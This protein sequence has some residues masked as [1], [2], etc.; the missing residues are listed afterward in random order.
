MINLNA[1][2]RKIVAILCLITVDSFLAI[3]GFMASAEETKC[4]YCGTVYGTNDGTDIVWELN[5]EGLLTLSG[6]GQMYAGS[7]GEYSKW[8]RYRNEIEEV[9]VG[10]NITSIGGYAFY[11]CENLKSIVLPESLE[12]I[13]ANAFSGCSSLKNIELPQG[14]ELLGERAFNGCSSLTD[15]VFPESIKTINRYC[16]CECTSLAEVVVPPNVTKLEYEVFGGCT[17]LSSVTLSEGLETLSNKVFRDCPI[18]KIYLPDSVQSISFF[19]FDGCEK[20][21]EVSIGKN[22]ETIGSYAFFENKSLKKVEYR[23]DIDSWIRINFISNP[24]EYAGDLYIDGKVVTKVDF[25]EGF[26]EIPKRVFQGCKSI[27]SI[28]IPGS[29]EKIGEYA[30]SGCIGLNEITFS[31]GIKTI[32]DYAFS[33]CLSISELSIPDSVTDICTAAF[34]GC[35][36]LQKITLPANIT[37]LGNNVFSGCRELSEISLPQSVEEIGGSCFKDCTALTKLILPEKIKSIHQFTF[38]GCSSLKIDWLPNFIETIESEA[39]GHCSNFELNNI[40]SSLKEIGDRAF[41][42][43]SKIKHVD[44]PEGVTRIGKGAFYLSG[45][46]SIIIRGNV[47]IIESETFCGCRN[48]KT[49]VIAEGTTEIGST[50]FASSGLTGIIIPKSVENLSSGAFRNCS[51]LESVTVYNTLQTVEGGA[52]DNDTALK[53]VNFIGSQSEWNRLNSSEHIS[54]GNDY[55]RNA[56]ISFAELCGEYIS[57]EFDEYSGE[58]KLIGHGDMFE[59]E[60]EIELPWYSV[61]DKIKTVSFEGEINKICDYAFYGLDYVESLAIPGSVSEI[62]DFAFG[63]CKNLKKIFIGN[64]VSAIG[65]YTFGECENVETIKLGVSVESIDK[66][67][68]GNT[69]RLTEIVIDPDNPHYVVSGP[70]LIE[71]GNILAAVLPGSALVDCIIPECIS[72]ISENAFSNCR[73][74]E[75]ITVSNKVVSIGK[76]AFSDCINLKKAEY[77]G[78]RSEWLKLSESDDFGSGN[79]ALLSADIIYSGYSCGDNIN[80]YYSE[81]TK[82]LIISGFGKMYNYNYST[83]PWSD[84]RNCL[85]CVEFIGDIT[86]LSDCAFA[87]CT[88][89]KEFEI[90][91][92]VNEIPAYM[93]EGCVIETISIGDSITYIGEGAFKNCTSLRQINVGNNVTFIGENAFLNTEYY[94][95]AGNYDNR[96]LYL[97]DS[98]KYLITAVNDNVN[99]AFNGKIHSRTVLV[100]SGAFRNIKCET[101]TLNNGLKYISSGAFAGAEIN[102]INFPATVVLCDEDVL[103]GSTVY[104]INYASERT[105]WLKM[106]INYSGTVYYTLKADDDRVEVIYC[107]DDLPEEAGNMEVCETT[108][109]TVE[110]INDF[111]QSQIRNSRFYN[112]DVTKIFDDMNISISNKYGSVQPL[113]G[114]SV[115]LRI[116]ASDDFADL[117]CQGLFEEFPEIVSVRFPDVSIE[118]GVVSYRQGNMVFETDAKT[119]AKEKRFKIY[120]WYSEPYD[121][122]FDGK[123]ERYFAYYLEDITLENGYIVLNV[124]HFSEFAMA[125]DCVD[126]EQNEYNVI[127]GEKIRVSCIHNSEESV[128]YS[129]SDSSVAEIDE[130]GFVIAKKNGEIV[131]YAY[132]DG[133]CVSQCNVIVLNPEIEIEG[134]R[135]SRSIECRQTLTFYASGVIPDGATVFWYYNGDKV[136]SGKTYTVTKPTNDYTIQC[137]VFND[138]GKIVAE[139]KTETIYVKHG[140]FNLLIAFIKDLLGLIPEIR[141]R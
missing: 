45:L 133:V 30:F 7:A 120:H 103:K 52:F 137:K 44:L 116:K 22:M 108:N 65:T 102:T 39:F 140:F 90:P 26:T 31:N 89:L 48:L 18:E 4:G 19:V 126:F 92:T 53:T 119:F 97:D 58:L 101:L 81:K 76:D 130:D 125:T 60:S 63:N 25:K 83:I 79:S 84:L 111:T 106:N 93:L 98:N 87:G 105:Q 33:K 141:Q 6:E 47:K 64:G 32:S 3:L 1:V 139:S 77:M 75:K 95:N 59:C 136:D 78:K 54:E 74:I 107:D 73:T 115:E 128:F 110:D 100:A 17:S 50:A 37:R 41:Y 123:D 118:N 27:K 117:I 80:G 2:R 21:E 88:E 67:A 96:I 71:E 66:S 5:E 8:Y 10:D 62:G 104:T 46:E 69:E 43:C 36:N 72:V 99:Q 24:T 127:A 38:S 70:F 138:R 13:D 91:E 131:V 16:F 86:E 57:F 20:L 29:V 23:G 109:I 112:K 34:S 51:S 121:D 132:I 55:F 56:D 14:V 124:P 61:K 40:P 11:D 129:V 122:N 134:Y 15:I 12:T 35:V 135:E 42:C 94:N 9:V 28:S 82:S 114:R 85:E 68:F 49:T 113:P